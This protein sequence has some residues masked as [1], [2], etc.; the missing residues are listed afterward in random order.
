MLNRSSIFAFAAIAALG[1]AW[2]NPSSAW[3][4]LFK[5]AVE[6]VPAAVERT[7]PPATGTLESGKTLESLRETLE[8]IHR[9][10]DQYEQQ[11]KE[12]KKKE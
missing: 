8:T 7:R 11:Q 4:S 9:L 10:Y 6:H 1:T 3:P 12:K 2:A 5:G